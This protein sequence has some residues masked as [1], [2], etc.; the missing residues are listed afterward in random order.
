MISKILKFIES[1]A[2]SLASQDLLTLIRNN[3]SKILWVIIGAMAVIT[4]IDTLQRGSCVDC[5]TLENLQK[6]NLLDSENFRENLM[7]REIGN[8][9]IGE[10]RKTKEYVPF[11]SA[12]EFIK[13]WLINFLPTAFLVVGLYF[14]VYF[15]FVFLQNKIKNKIKKLKDLNN[16]RN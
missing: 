1:K 9:A 7:D 10:W 6:E 14:F 3:K 16:D 15:V 2:R 5:Y 12:G 13:V 4:F 8:T 11:T